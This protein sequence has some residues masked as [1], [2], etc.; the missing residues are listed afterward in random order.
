MKK[1][2]LVKTMLVMTAVLLVLAACSN[3]NNAG[4]N[5]SPGTESNAPSDSASAANE[6]ITLFVDHPWWPFSD[7]SG[8]IPE[9]IT[10]RTGI[11]VKIQVAA[12]EQQLPLMIAS[13][14]AM[15]DIVYTATTHQQMSSSDVSY[16]WD[17]LIEKYN[18][19]GFNIDP[20]AR[21][22]NAMDDGNL[23]TVRNGFMS[24]DAFDKCEKCLN[25]G[26]GMT[27]RE[28]IMQEL[29]NPKLETMDDY[30]D[31]LKQVKSKYP[32]LIPAV[33]TPG[34]IG[35]YLRLNFGAP[36]NMF[37]FY[38]DG[39]QP[40]YYIDHPNQKDFYLYVNKLYR[41]GLISA[42]NFAWKE[43]TEAENYIVGDKAFSLISAS[44]DS[45]SINPRLESEGKSFKLRQ[46]T[47]L[48]GAQPKV[49]WNEVGWSGMYVPKTAKN[50][51]TAI[52]FIQFMQSDEGQRLAT[53]GV[54]GDDWT[55]NEAE[56]YPEFNYDSQN[57]EIQKELGVVWWGILASSGE[58]EKVQRYDPS[59]VS[60]EALL[61]L[62][63]VTSYN[64]LLGKLIPD[65]DSEEQ[66]ILSNLDNMIKNEETRI[67]LAKN[68]DEAVQAFDA[69]MKKAEEIGLS[70]LESWAKE[71]YT[72]VESSI[73]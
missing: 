36:T 9:E 50:A 40:R 43:R 45:E 28:D 42:E 12:D 16:T 2:S 5:A 6:E 47:N 39:D 32:K 53:W 62:K 57:A 20:A 25:A 34:E 31:I 33:I 71:R 27:V 64:P 15:P 13:G 60:S 63:K 22:V 73:K 21:A 17:E 56:G 14:A 51:E 37:N 23:Y 65:T 52:K 26:Q 30:F 61:N 46:V 29:G 58:V 59:S 3:E 1:A 67:Y 55:W 72:Q 19:Q 68:E 54:E 49:F 24:S 41:E 66:V 69:M 11:K 7:W 35:G 38:L 44:G 48:L 18:V 4:S 70:K 8:K 10:K